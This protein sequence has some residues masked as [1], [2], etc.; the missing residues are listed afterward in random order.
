MVNPNTELA[1]PKAKIDLN[2][3]LSTHYDLMGK[4][5]GA[6]VMYCCPFHEDSTP[7]FSVSSKNLWNCHAGCGGGSVIDFVMKKEKLDLGDAIKRVKE[8]EP[9]A[10]PAKTNELKEVAAY[11]YRDEAG[12]LLYQS[13]RYEPK[14]FRQ[15]RP[16]GAGG[17]AWNMEGVRRVPYRLPELLAAEHE[18]PIFIVEGEKDANNLMRAGLVATCN[19]GGAGKWREEYNPFFAGRHVVIIPDNDEPGSKHAAMVV[20][21]LKPVAASVKLLELTGLAEKGDVSDWLNLGGLGHTAAELMRLAEAKKEWQPEAEPAKAESLPRTDR[22]DWHT[23]NNNKAA[24]YDTTADQPGRPDSNANPDAYL[25]HFE[26]TDDGNA[27]A[28]ISLYGEEFCHC[29]VYGWMAWT[30][31]HFKHSGGEEARLTVKVIE[32]LKRRRAAAAFSQVESVVKWSVPN[33]PKVSNCITLLRSKLAVNAKEFDSNPDLLNCSNGVLDLRTGELTPHNPAQRFTYCTAVPY[34]P[35]ADCFQWEDFLLGAIGGN[36]EKLVYLQ[37]LLGYGLTGHTFEECMGYLLGA[38][39]NGKG[40]LTEAIA[41]VLGEPLATAADFESLTSKREGGNQNFDLAPLKAARFV[42]ASEGKT[43]TRLNEAKVKQLTGGDT[44]SCAFKHQNAFTF[45]PQFLVILSSNHPIKADADDLAFWSRIKVIEFPNSYI[46]REDKSLKR[47]LHSATAL[48]G[49]LCWMVKGAMQWYQTGSDGLKTPDTIKASTEAQRTENDT[50]LL[51]LEA[52][53]K[54]D[55]PTWVE[56]QRVYESYE[57]F[58]A[59]NGYTEKKMP[60]LSTSLKTKGYTVGVHGRVLVSGK[61][62]RGVQGLIIL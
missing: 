19:V 33:T 49:L 36:T 51:W 12:Q 2:D 32:V 44:I 52:C 1:E 60:G 56:N 41:K 24:H 31:T 28:F 34:N 11:D 47:R 15:R 62:S 50:V 58:C 13:V 6:N 29:G 23:N 38:G 37:T 55:E 30:G 48:Q 17:W 4:K 20:G 9:G 45:K 43:Q 61:V 8:L 54:R 7:S 10:F 40:T 59:E 22:A 3:F 46:G 42:F 53:T 27:E 16:D 5:S 21:H 35:D 57:K 25:A 26:P 14:T 39:R 18:T